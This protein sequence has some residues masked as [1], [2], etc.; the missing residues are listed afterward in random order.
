M[1]LKGVSKKVV[2]IKSPDP[3]YFE[4]AIFILRDDILKK[5]GKS[6]QKILRDAERVARDYLASCNIGPV[7]RAPGILPSVIIA[8]V[9]ALVGIAMIVAG[10]IF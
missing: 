6:S 10:F 7:K 8:G 3:R 9:I 5:G 1:L 4:Q 2:V